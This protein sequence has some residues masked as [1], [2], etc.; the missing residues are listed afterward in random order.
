MERKSPQRPK[1]PINLERA[2]D[3]LT[4]NH[5]RQG[6]QRFRKALCD[7]ARLQ[8]V[9]ALS[10]GRLCVN[11]LAMAIDRAPAATSQHLRILRD[12]D[13]VDGERE[14]TTVY[15]SLKRDAGAQLEGLLDQMA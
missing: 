7:P 2:R 9:Q 1:D 15:Y 10:V 4:K 6:M 12:L 8:I 14:G 13:I 11:D 5:A 3:R